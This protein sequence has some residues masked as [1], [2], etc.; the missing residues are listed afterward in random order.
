MAA[1]SEATS[2]VLTAR[3]TADTTR[4]FRDAVREAPIPSLAGVAFEAMGLA[5][6]FGALAALTILG[7][8][9]DDQAVMSNALARRLEIPSGVGALVFFALAAPLILVATRIGAGL[10]RIAAPGA[11]EG[12]RATL[13]NAWRSGAA[14]QVSA[15]GIWLQIFGMMTSATMVLLG[16][17][18]ILSYVV[19]PDTLGPFSGI[20]SGLAL[21]LT[22]VY[23]AELGA[24]QEL[25]TASLVRH[26]RGVG[27][28]VLHAW[29]LMKAQPGTSRRK[30]AGDFAARFAIVAVS[31]AVGGSAGPLWGLAQFVVLG[32][33]FGAIRC[34]AWALL[35]PR[36]GG[37]EPQV[38]ARDE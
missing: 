4:V 24:L 18:V 19:G 15:F 35:Y 28:A 20:L 36:I 7:A 9:V 34:H 11:P 31:L 14:V 33:L 12:R 26:R 17:L 27:S 3:G 32:A 2:A 21:T 13:R 30:A 29:R 16:P 38:A 37:L 5:W 10:A 23:G 1:A 22:F 6:V 8:I 25:A